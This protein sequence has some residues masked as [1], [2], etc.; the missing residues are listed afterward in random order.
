MATFRKKGG[1][2]LQAISTASLPD[3]VF[4]LLFF[5]MST[6]HMKENTFQ[7]KINLPQATQLTKLEKKSLVRYVYIGAPMDAKLGNDSRLQLDDQIVDDPHKVQDYITSQRESMKEEDQGMM[8][9]SLKAD[10]DTKMGII[11]D[12]KQALRQANALKINYTAKKLL[13]KQYQAPK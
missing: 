8:V 7:V 3:I 6:T 2:K 1:K 9:V 11:S 13:N 5:F 10:A 12:V 4:M